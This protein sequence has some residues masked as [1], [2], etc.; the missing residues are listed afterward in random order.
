VQSIFVQDDRSIDSTISVKP[1]ADRSHTVPHPYRPYE[2]QCRY[3]SNATKDPFCNAA[4]NSTQWLIGALSY[5]AFLN[6]YPPPE[7]FSMSN[8]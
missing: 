4:H 8:C 6:D 5:K 2:Y 1:H 3:I 7:P